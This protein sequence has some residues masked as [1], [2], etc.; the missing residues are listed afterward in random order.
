MTSVAPKGRAPLLDF[1]VEV[2][3]YDWEPLEDATEILQSERETLER[4]GA[5]LA[6]RKEALARSGRRAA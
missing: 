5:E 4:L 2:Y 1:E 6:E 3:S